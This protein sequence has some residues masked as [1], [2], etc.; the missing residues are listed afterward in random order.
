MYFV[1][2]IKPELSEKG[3]GKKP[4]ADFLPFLLSLF[5][6]FSAACGGLPPAREGRAG[7]AV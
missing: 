5:L 7:F 2:S 4:N 1:D 6:L 3:A